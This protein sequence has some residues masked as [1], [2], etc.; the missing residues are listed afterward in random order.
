MSEKN[1]ESD[2]RDETQ[3][4][5]RQAEGEPPVEAPAEAPAAS[6]AA[7]PGV[8]PAAAPAA[9]PRGFRQRLRGWRTSGDGSRAYSLGA[10]IASA[11]AGVI[12]GG[13]GL[14]TVQAIADDGDR[15]GWFEHRGPMGRDGFWDRDRDFDDRG[16]MFRGPGDRGRLLPT[17]PPD[18]EDDSGN[19]DGSAS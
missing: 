12:V 19:E 5:R 9:A 11:L 8:G 14:A 15:P 4:V 16:P 6:E 2:S 18:D 17:T 7:G 10:L 3:P 1:G 13:A